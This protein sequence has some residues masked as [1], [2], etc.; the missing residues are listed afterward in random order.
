M[1]VAFDAASTHKGAAVSSLTWSHTC[2]GSNRLLVVGVSNY[3]GTADG[4]GRYL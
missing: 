2:T 3:S 4:D 1:A